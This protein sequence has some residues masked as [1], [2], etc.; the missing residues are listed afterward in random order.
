MSEKFGDRMMQACKE[1]GL[2]REELAKKIGTSG[3][4]VGRYERGDMMPSVE[5]ATKIADALTVSLDFL[6]GKSSL[7]VKDVNILER[8][9]DIA[10]LPE[11]KKIELFNIM[12]AYLRDFK[13]SRTYSK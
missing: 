12:D 7:I 13:T 9:E 6:V 1:N 3:P 11:D 8:M 5:I 10:K 2:F 4:I